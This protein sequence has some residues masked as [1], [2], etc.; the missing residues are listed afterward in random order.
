MMCLNMTMGETQPRLV[1]WLI[2]GCFFFMALNTTLHLSKY[3]LFLTIISENDHY[4]SIIQ[5][6]GHIYMCYVT[7][8][9]I[10]LLLLNFL[11]GSEKTSFF[12]HE[13]T[14]LGVGT[15]SKRVWGGLNYAY[16]RKHVIDRT[17]FNTNSIDTS[18]MYK[19]Q[20]CFFWSNI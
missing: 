3:R 16:P 15:Y 11:K 10:F 8:R 2:N 1:H 4:I 17:I 19:T 6:I 5:T 18:T 20:I 12:R 7:L 13:Y 14:W 9:G